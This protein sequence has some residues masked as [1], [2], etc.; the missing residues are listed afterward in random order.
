MHPASRERSHGLS[1]LSR[2]DVFTHRHLSQPTPRPSV[3]SVK[4]KPCILLGELYHTPKERKDYAGPALYPWLSTPNHRSCPV[5]LH[6][7]LLSSLKASLAPA[8]SS[9]SH[10]A[11]ISVIQTCTLQQALPVGRNSFSR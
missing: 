6:R 3:P 11:V 1:L 8:P 5:L 10:S 4:L 9:D 2:G 7:L